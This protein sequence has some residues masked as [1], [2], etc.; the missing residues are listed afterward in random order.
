MLKTHY[1]KTF[2]VIVYFVVGVKVTTKNYQ[3]TF[4]NNTDYHVQIVVNHLIKSGFENDK[5]KYNRYVVIVS[6]RDGVMRQ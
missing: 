2:F 6:C 1:E 3:V 4:F 5:E